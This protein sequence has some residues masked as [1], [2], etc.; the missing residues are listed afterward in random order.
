MSPL[1]IKGFHQ[2]RFTEFHHC[3]APTV[4][5]HLASQRE[6]RGKE[7][8]PPVLEEF[9][10]CRETKMSKTKMQIISPGLL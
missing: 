6:A 2:S 5:R 4:Y 3:L 10:V 1:N 8:I 9:T 7:D